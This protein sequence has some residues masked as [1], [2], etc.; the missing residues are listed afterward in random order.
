MPP[1]PVLPSAAA[2]MQSNLMATQRAYTGTVTK[3]QAD[4]GFIDDEIFFHK[5]VVCKG[6]MPKVGEHVFV[7][8]SYASNTPFKWNASRVQLLTPSGQGAKHKRNIRIVFNCFCISVQSKS[9]YNNHN[10]SSENGN[11]SRGNMNTSSNNMR[12]VN[13]SSHRRSRSPPPRRS[14]DRSNSKR[15]SS[16]ND[17]RRR[18]ARDER[19]KRERRDRGSSPPPKTPER[20]ERRTSRPVAAATGTSSSATA[21]ATAASVGSPPPLKKRRRMVPRYMVQIPK[22]ALAMVR[23]DVQELKQR[24][25]NLYIPSDFFQTEILWPETFT[26]DKPFVLRQP[27]SFHLMYKDIVPPPELANDESLLEPP[28]ADH[29]FSARVMLMSVPPMSD[30]YRQCFSAAEE[31]EDSDRNLVHPSRTISFLMG[32]RGK[33][34]TMGIGGP[35]SPSLDGKNPES[36]PRVLIRTAIRTCKA[37]TGIDLSRCTQWYE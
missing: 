3:I 4:V 23:A 24:Y 27:C 17:R 35:W 9:S 26:P 31:E 15:D 19:D 7:E 5:S 37:L 20:R 16:D 30:I 8:A 10:S 21:T 18:S 25:Q 2:V 32:L 13:H 6:S 33:N 11:Y 28:D 36:D 14:L 29:S 34:E 22:V 12:S 1:L